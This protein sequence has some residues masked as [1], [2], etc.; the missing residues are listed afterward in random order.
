MHGAA[1]RGLEETGQLRRSEGTMDTQHAI[2]PADRMKAQGE[3][4]HPQSQGREPR[5]LQ[6]SDDH[7]DPGD[8]HRLAQELVGPRVVKMV[9]QER[10]D[11]HVDGR[12]PEGERKRVGADSQPFAPR[13]DPREGFAQVNPDTLGPD[14]GARRHPAHDV[15]CASHSGTQVEH[16]HGLRDIAEQGAYAQRERAITTEPSVAAGDVAV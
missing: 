12:V 4:R 6:V 2:V 15:S 5:A 7:P 9:E 13:G 14:S 1:S 16:G 11:R 3:G 10:T 8:A